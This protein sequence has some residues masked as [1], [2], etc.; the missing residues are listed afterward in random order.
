MFTLRK[1]RRARYFRIT[2]SGWLFLLLIV[3]VAAVGA[4]KRLNLI[5][6]IVSF[7]I[8][9][10]LV[11]QL[12]S[13]VG[14]YSLSVRRIV[15]VHIFAEKPFPVEIQITNRKRTFACYSL[16][17]NETIDGAELPERY[18]IKI[19][20]ETTVSA[21]YEHRMNHRGAYQFEGTR[22]STRFP[23]DFFVRGFLEQ[24][25]EEIVIYPKVVKLNP[26]FLADLMTEI[27]ARLN[28]PGPGSE[29]YGFRKY[30]HGDDS[31][32]INWKLTAKTS[33]VT[34]TKFSEDQDLHMVVVFDNFMD[35]EPQETPAA[36]KD[37][38]AEEMKRFD[39]AV[40]FVASISSFFIEKGYKLKLVTQDGASDF[41]EGA[42]HLFRVLRRLAL[43]Q[44]TPAA[45]ARNDIYHP[46]QL[47][48]RLGIL[49]TYAHEHPPSGHFIHTFYARGIKEL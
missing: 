24:N 14:L 8:S 31:R 10:M 9:F 28:R 2:R 49:V 36:G 17:V 11:S 47:E 7:M 20:P 26:N 46:S 37:V 21:T 44:P 25:D 34:V 13:R 43:I 30:A 23:L 6:L 48:G 15:P 32:T 45:D 22:I 16:T 29:V 42:K 41:G 3:G 1:S 4:V 27:D 33:E 19:P 12:L 38:K 5:Y 35:G 18:L 39:S 40:R